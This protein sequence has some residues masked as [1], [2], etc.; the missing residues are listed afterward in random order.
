MTTTTNDPPATVRFL[1]DPGCPWTW[2]T[3]RLVRE[4]R[5]QQPLTV[6]WGLYALEYINR[7]NPDNPYLP[8]LRRN[9]LALRLLEVAR[10]QGGEEAIDRLYEVLGTACHERGQD[11]GDRAVLQAALVEAGLS[12]ALLD[13][14]EAQPE[15]DAELERQYAAAEAQGA[16]ATPTLV[17]DG[18]APVYGPVIETVPEGAEAV[19]LWAAVRGLA[20]RPYFFELKR[21]R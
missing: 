17:V 5:R 13:Q 2:R 18:A 15:I 6:E 12:A 10:R 16:I 21:P 14:A 11:L 20:T 3:A 7:A 19:A 9:R 4:V 1:F 8:L